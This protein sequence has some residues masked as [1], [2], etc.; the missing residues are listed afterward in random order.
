MKRNNRLLGIAILLSLAICIGNWYK[1]D[2]SA[3]NELQSD[4][5]RGNWSN[6][7]IHQ[8]TKMCEQE[9]PSM[10]ENSVPRSA[11][12][13]KQRYE[14]ERADSAQETITGERRLPQGKI[15][16]QFGWQQEEGVWRYHTG[17]DLVPTSV[18]TVSVTEGSVSRIDKV[19]GGYRLE[20]V[21]ENERWQYEPLCEIRVAIGEKITANTL[22]GKCSDTLHIARKRDGNW[23]EPSAK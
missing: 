7:P 22:I 14:T 6:Q 15:V 11:Q 8:V 20:I 21:R 4:D 18:E 16:R 23:I 2:S 12:H 19:A 1:T 3:G 17:I 5:D 13:D 9:E 10:S